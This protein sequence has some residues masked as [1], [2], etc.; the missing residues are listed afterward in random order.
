M[1][2][3]KI[4]ANSV[5]NYLSGRLL[6]QDKLNRL[7]DADFS[8][9]VR[10]LIDYGYGGG[11][12][13]ANSYDIDK[14]ITN[15]TQSLIEFVAECSAS[16]ELASC[17]LN[18]F[19]YLDA[20]VLFKLKYLG[21]EPNNSLYIKD[22][23]FRSA[24]TSG[25]YS[26][27]PQF[28]IDACN[29][30]TEKSVSS[31][32]TAKEIDIAFTKAMYLDNLKS[33]KSSRNKSLIGYC[34]A[35]IDI[36]NILSAF[37]AKELSMT[38]SQLQDEIYDGGNIKLE[39][40]MEILS[41]ESVAIVSNFSNTEYADVVAK[42]VED[43]DVAGYLKETDEILFNFLQG[44]SNDMNSFSPFINYFNAQILEYKTIKLILV[45]LKNNI[46]SAIKP[47]IRSFG[48]E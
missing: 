43:N 17:L 20:K 41:S 22:E 18:R 34:T 28:M 46:K 36:S 45:C 42:L 9:A 24:F 39:N 25:D 7:I 48:N 1:V 16:E 29:E 10:M 8:D 35:Q 11:N 30:L 21:Q 14:F 40:I 23:D 27:L 33:A 5:A 47:R 12:L 44:K 6:G 37:R 13:D 19:Y 3:T 31:K 4:Y 32:L 15:E 2:V 26:V 38:A